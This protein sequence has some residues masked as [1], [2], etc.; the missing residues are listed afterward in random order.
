MNPEY[1]RVFKPDL[2]TTRAEDFQRWASLA[3]ATAI[4]AYGLSRRSVGGVC[5]AVAATP[6]A[7]RGGAA[8]WP[9][10]G[11]GRTNGDTRDALSGDRGIH[12]R[13]SVRLEKP[14]ADVY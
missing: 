2:G 6:L 4:V 13:E 12:V 8:R 7:Y 9:R 1:S 14:I 5:V 10:G 3:T 11:S